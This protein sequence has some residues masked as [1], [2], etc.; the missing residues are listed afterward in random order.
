MK[1][2]V[3]GCLSI[4]API[5]NGDEMREVRIAKGEVYSWKHN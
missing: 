2:K 1:N 5:L 3:L 4:L